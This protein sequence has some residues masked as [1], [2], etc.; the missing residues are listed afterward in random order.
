MHARPFPAFVGLGF[1]KF[2]VTLQAS[3]S[4]VVTDSNT[5]CRFSKKWCGRDVSAV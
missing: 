2:D 4:H 5:H 1:M 3:R